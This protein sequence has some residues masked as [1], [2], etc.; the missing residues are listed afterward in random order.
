MAIDKDSNGR[1]TAME[2]QAALQLGGLNFSL[3]TVA[4]IIRIHDRSNSGSITFD[5]FSKLH[6]FLTNVQHSFEYFDQD[7][8]NSLSY[9]EIFNALTHAGYQ[10]DRPALQAVFQR[11]DPS[12]S[13][14]LGLTE[15]LALTLFLRSATATFNCSCFG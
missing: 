14:A 7:R 5:E 10:L 8:S 11:F 15:F 2:L 9:D 1:L 13:G 12:R 3:A 6:E 4:H